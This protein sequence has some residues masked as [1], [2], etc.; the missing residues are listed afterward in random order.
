VVLDGFKESRKLIRFGRLLSLRIQ[1]NFKKKKGEQYQTQ[2][3]FKKYSYPNMV[4][5]KVKKRIFLPNVM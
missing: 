5:L 2:T 1:T 4:N 3:T